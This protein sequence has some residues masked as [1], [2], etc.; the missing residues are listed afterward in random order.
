MQIPTITTPRL[1]LRSFDTSDVNPLHGI[2]NTG[3]VLRYFPTSDPPARDRVERL[4]AHQLKHWEEHEYGWWAVELQ[5]T[6][7]LIGWNGLQYLPETK[8]VEVG[9]LLAKGFWGRGLATEGARTSVKYGFER[10]RLQ[11]IIGI[12]HPENTASQRVLK[13]LGMSLTGPA[14]Y[15]GMDCLHFAVDRSSFKPTRP[16]E[17]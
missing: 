16:G 1:T 13:K 4:I 14:H 2:L 3:D 10:L 5:E 7:E 6:G 15:F 17:S 9:Y 8:E 12:T 11:T